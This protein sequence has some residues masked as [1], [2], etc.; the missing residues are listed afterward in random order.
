MR[1]F[2]EL[3]VWQK[4]HRFAL[5]VYGATCEFP[6]EER[7]GLCAQLRRAAVSIHAEANR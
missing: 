5:D 2:K 6:S 4:A 1:D 7:F 3:Y